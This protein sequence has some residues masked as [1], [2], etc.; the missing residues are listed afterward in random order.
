M[1]RIDEIYGVFKPEMERNQKR[2]SMTYKE[3]ETNV[4]ELKK[5]TK[6]RSNNVKKQAKSFFNLS[7]K[8]MEKYFG[9]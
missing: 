9:G 3:W 5:F 4:E 8:E 7:N 1:N 6:V 2:W